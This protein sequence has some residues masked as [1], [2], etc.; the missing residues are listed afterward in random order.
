[1]IRPCREQLQILAFRGRKIP[2]TMES[3][4]FAEGL[5]QIVHFRA[6]FS[7]NCPRNRDTLG[8]RPHSG[9]RLVW[10]T[11]GH[12]GGRYAAG[13]GYRENTVERYRFRL[14]R[15]ALQSS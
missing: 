15:I 14:N 4:G 10:Q 1:M 11:P 6:L 3:D 5:R 8:A 13:S 2:R 9:E 7:G 12:A